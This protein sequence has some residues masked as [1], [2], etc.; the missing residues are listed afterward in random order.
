MSNLKDKLT[1]YAAI[2]FAAS[3]TVL[4][5]PAALAA[6]SPEITFVLPSIVNVI[7][8]IVIAVSIVITQTLTG[9]NPD[10][11]TKTPQQ[12]EDAKKG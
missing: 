5:L 7:C 12:I 11:T 8:G 2:G 9:K 4:G 6:V 1:T 10:G 3:V